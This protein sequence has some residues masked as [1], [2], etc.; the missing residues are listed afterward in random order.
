MLMHLEEKWHFYQNVSDGVFFTNHHH[1]VRFSPQ[2][3]NFIVTVQ[4][5]RLRAFARMAILEA[6]E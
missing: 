4:G 5:T 2:N 1:A 3:F 6:I